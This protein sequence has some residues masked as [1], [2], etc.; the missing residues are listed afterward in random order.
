[1]HSNADIEV[2]IH[3]PTV[4]EFKVNLCQTNM[5]KILEEYIMKIVDMM[6]C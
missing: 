5:K 6:L 1:M 3:F 2:G 4:H